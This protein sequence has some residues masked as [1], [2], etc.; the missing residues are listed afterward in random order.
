MSREEKLLHQLT[1]E[2]LKVLSNYPDYG[3]LGLYIT[4]HNSQP[5]KIDST[6]TV[7]MKV[8]KEVEK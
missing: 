7:T 5:V 8:K 1:P 2:L 4:L 3:S 6:R